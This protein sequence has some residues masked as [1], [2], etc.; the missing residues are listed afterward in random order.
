MSTLAH[1]PSPWEIFFSGKVV[2]RKAKAAVPHDMG[3]PGEDPWF[4]VNAYCIQGI[5]H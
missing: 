2:E 1:D 5:I 4:K 3:N